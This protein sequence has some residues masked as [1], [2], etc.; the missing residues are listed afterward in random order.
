LSVKNTEDAENIARKFIQKRFDYA[1]VTYESVDF[2]G[3]YF[4]VKGECA[5]SDGSEEKEQ[6]VLKIKTDGNVVGWQLT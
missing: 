3:T 2:D 5:P 1:S 4:Y 6:F